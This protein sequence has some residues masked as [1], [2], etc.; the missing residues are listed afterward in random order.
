MK[1]TGKPLH[2]ETAEA[3][4]AWLERN[5]DTQDDVWLTIYKKHSETPSVTLMQAMEE[6]IC[7]GW[8]DS[9]MQPVDAERYVLR[10]T[11]RRK[12]SNWSE[13]NKGW[14]ARLIEEGRMTDAGLAKIEEAKRSGRWGK[15]PGRPS[16]PGGVHPEGRRHRPRPAQRPLGGGERVLR[17]REGGR[18]LRGGPGTD[19]DS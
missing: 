9:Q 8:I 16:A 18:G 11:P 17:R 15:V 1:M 7:F 5:H 3:W 6:A 13:R 4:R 2:F 10:F 12:T 19:G 14:A